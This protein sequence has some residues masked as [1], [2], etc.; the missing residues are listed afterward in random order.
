MTMP[1]PFPAPC[2]V[3]ATTRRLIALQGRDGLWGGFRLQPGESREW[4]GA[5]AARALAEAAASGR[6]PAALARLAWQR[7]GRASAVLRGAER[8]GGGWGYDRLVPP[9]S[10]STAAVLRLFAALGQSAPATAVAFLA[11]QGSPVRGWATYGPMRCWDAWSQPCPEVDAAAALALAGAGA[12]DRAG[13]AEAW[14]RLASMADGRGHWRAYWWP[15]PGVATLAALQLWDAAGR[16]EPYPIP[17]VTGA[18]GVAIPPMTEDA[19]QAPDLARPGPGT[20]AE[21]RTT[22]AAMTDAEPPATGAHMAGGP[23]PGNRL[24]SPDAPFP[25]WIAPNPETGARANVGA[26]PSVRDAPAAGC[27][28]GM[29]TLDLLT[30]AQARG[31][32][33]AAAGGR[34]LAHACARMAGPGRWPADAVLLAPPRYPASD[35]GETSPEGRGVLTTAAAL[36]ALIALPPVPGHRAADAESHWSRAA[37]SGRRP[38][39]PGPCPDAAPAAPRAPASPAWATTTAA[40]LDAPTQRAGL[41]AVPAASILT[42]PP[43]AR[44][45][46]APPPADAVAAGLGGLARGLGLSPAT[47]AL[48][49]RAGAALLGPLLAAPLPWPNRAVSNLARGWPVEF[50]ATLDPEARP[51]L[52]MAVDLGDPRLSPGA[53]ARTARKSLAQAAA[54]LGLDA[55]MLTAG[56]GPL[57]RAARHA[58]PGERFTLWAGLD[59]TETAAAPQPILKAYGNLALAGPEARDRLALASATI[60]ALGGGDHL[61]A[62][63]DLNAVLQ[64]RG[65][66]Q[67]IGLALTPRGTGAKVYWELPAHD[68]AATLDLARALGLAHPGFTPEIPRLASLAD[69]GRGLSGLAVRLDPGTGIRPELTLA[70]QAARAVGWHTTHEAAALSDWGAALGLDATAAI[71]LLHALRADGPA[72]RSLHTL[73][74]TASGLRAAIYLHADGWLRRRLPRTHRPPRAPIAAP[75]QGGMP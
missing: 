55:G 75:I 23:T 1:A 57:L 34:A 44:P 38:A 63:M 32:M 59:L 27:M 52:R 16:P 51:A 50:S 10:D 19:R 25:A 46:P 6:L 68:R 62:L 48:A 37:T 2:P 29:S 43:I 9:D 67:Q 39:P 26:S 35:G 12:L 61:P 13:L 42:A 3:I 15:G 24:P 54:I 5:V 36:G 41:K 7:A 60:A 47:A 72:P 70:T 8:P 21:A 31:I 40:G 45:N 18:D 56:L 64:G 33:D 74:L 22:C 28:A 11:A 49:R 69:A 73:T 53:R 4:V 17:P 20:A 30:L 65:Q 58:D 14:R 71:A 66:P